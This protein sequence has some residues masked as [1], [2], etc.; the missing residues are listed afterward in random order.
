MADPDTVGSSGDG[1]VAD[2]DVAATTFAV[3][4]LLYFFMNNDDDDVEKWW[5]TR[6]KI[7]SIVLSVFIHLFLFCLF[8]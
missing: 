3:I 4:F 6:D 8:V 2:T 7:D 5:K 1:G